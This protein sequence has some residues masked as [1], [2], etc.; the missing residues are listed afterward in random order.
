MRSAM[1]TAAGVAGGMLAAN[2]IS[3]M[4]SG[5]GSTPGAQTA[6]APTATPTTNEPASTSPEQVAGE[7]ET[8]ADDFDNGD[9]AGVYDSSFDDDGD[10]GSDLEL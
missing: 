2:A 5:H 10:W 8:G 1:T 4:L 9:D 3:S 6:A 7:D